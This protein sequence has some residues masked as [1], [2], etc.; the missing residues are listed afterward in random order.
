[1]HPVP[2]SRICILCLLRCLLSCPLQCLGGL[3]AIRH[4]R[5]RDSLVVDDV[6]LLPHRRLGIRTV[7]VPIVLSHPFVVVLVPVTRAGPPL[8]DDDKS[9][10]Y[11]PNGFI[12]TM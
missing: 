10:L 8:F 6:L 3:S 7:R 5:L 2:Y 1:M 12:V 11:V 4:T 9:V